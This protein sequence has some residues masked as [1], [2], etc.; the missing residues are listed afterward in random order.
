MR[1][2]AMIATC[3]AGTA[4]MRL[5]ASARAADQVVALWLVAVFASGSVRRDGL[6]M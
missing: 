6:S 3:A 4:L 5:A 1:P 2:E